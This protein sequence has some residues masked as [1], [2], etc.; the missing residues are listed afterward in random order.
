MRHYV[1]RA[2]APDP[3]LRFRAHLGILTGVLIGVTIAA[4]MGI[5]FPLLM[6]IGVM[7][8]VAVL[9]VPLWRRARRARSQTS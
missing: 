1:V 3:K 4:V 6:L 2:R 5:F 9:Y 8:V 7:I